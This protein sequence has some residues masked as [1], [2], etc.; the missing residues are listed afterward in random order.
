MKVMTSPGTLRPITARDCWPVGACT[1]PLGPAAPRLSA[2]LTVGPPGGQHID[3]LRVESTD[4][5]PAHVVVHYDLNS[6][7]AQFAELQRSFETRER[8][9]LVRDRVACGWGL[10]GLVDG[11]VRALRVLREHNVACDYV[12]LLSGSCMPTKP[13]A[14]L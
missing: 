3:V 2:F 6:P 9:W 10:F 5:S 14:T 4:L 7:D 11:V 8:A 12:Y 1:S 13:L